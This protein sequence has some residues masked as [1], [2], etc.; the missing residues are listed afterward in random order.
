MQKRKKPIGLI[1]ALVI[2]SI[3][4]VGGSIGCFF[5]GRAV[6]WQEAY[7]KGFEDGR[8]WGYELGKH[9]E[10]AYNKAFSDGKME[11]YNFMHNWYNAHGILP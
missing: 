2:V 5:I 9:D 10:E 6:T 8:N 4:A 7:D 3:L 1:I 11:M